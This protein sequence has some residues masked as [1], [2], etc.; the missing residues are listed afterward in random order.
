MCTG[1][2]YVRDPM[3]NSLEWATA[4]E[5]G[6]EKKKLEVPTVIQDAV[7][8]VCNT[9]H[10]ALFHQ[11]ISCH[12]NPL[13]HHHHLRRRCCRPRLDISKQPAH[14]PKLRKLQCLGNF[15]RRWRWRRRRVPRGCQLMHM[16]NCN[17]Y[18]PFLGGC[19]SA[20]LSLCPHNKVL[21]FSYKIC[22][23][24]CWNVLNLKSQFLIYY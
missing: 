12:I 10:T 9:Q 4:C 1:S 22:N 8:P 23:V 2:R 18:A 17:F 16:K 7:C 5:W 24:L 20:C 15:W 11:I 3:K 21:Q 6:A 14:D 13:Y 19:V